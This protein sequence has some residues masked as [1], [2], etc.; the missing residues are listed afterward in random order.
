MS[1]P[2]FIVA[3]QPNEGKTTVVATLTE[4]SKAEISHIPGT[5]RERKKYTIT[6]DGEDRLYVFDTPGF[7]NPGELLEWFRENAKK[8]DNPAQ[9]FLN[10]QSHLTQ[11]PY[12][13]EILKPIAEGG[14]IIHVINP[15]REVMEEDHWEAEIFQLCRCTRI[16]LL[17]SRNNQKQYLKDWERLLA[18]KA[19]TYLEFDAKEAVFADRIKLLEAIAMVLPNR[20]SG[21]EEVVSFVSAD[22]HK[23]IAKTAGRIVENMRQAVQH[24]ISFP[25]TEDSKEKVK[26]EANKAIPEYVRKLEK[27]FRNDVRKR[28]RHLNDHWEY[29]PNLDL[30]IMHE[31][32]WQIFGFSKWQIVFACAMAGAGTGTLIDIATGGGTVGIGALIGAVTAGAAAYMYADRAV[33][34]QFP[35]IELPEVNLGPLGT[36]KTKM[37]GGPLGGRSLVARIERKSKL[38]SILLDR[39]TSYSV[40]VA[41]WAH[42]KRQTKGLSK[43]NENDNISD[44]LTKSKE[45]ERLQALIELWYSPN[46]EKLGASEMQKVEASEEWFRGK[47]IEHIVQAT[48][49]A[50]P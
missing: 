25:Y 49:G 26:A 3:G 19:N 34:I 29:D 39:M 21:L 9:A 37:G 50:T 24:R 6:I 36:F 5:T 20:N 45:V 42:G 18:E 11:Y 10:V 38:P 48:M 12:D 8:H 46:D 27:D 14:A 33:E 16:G 1:I 2:K 41:R 31:D 17:N 15:A 44:R 28:F 22:W 47:I 13:C 32:T 35:K 23:R 30:D 7:E 43:M 40:A 4:D